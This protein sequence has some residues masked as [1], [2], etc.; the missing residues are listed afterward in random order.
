[1]LKLAVNIEDGL[2]K[3]QGMNQF[4]HLPRSNQSDQRPQQDSYNQDSIS[5]A[6]FKSQQQALAHK[7]NAI[8]APVK[9]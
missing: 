9:S 4:T 5:P 6:R 7:A 1:M 3:A 8:Q 2:N